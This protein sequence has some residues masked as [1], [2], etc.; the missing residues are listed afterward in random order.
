MKYH[1]QP[2][3][4][5]WLLIQAI[6]H[7]PRAWKVSRPTKPLP[8]ATGESLPSESWYRSNVLIVGD[9]DPRCQ[10]HAPHPQPLW[11]ANRGRN[12][13]GCRRGWYKNTPAP[14]PH[15]LQQESSFAERIQ[16]A[17]CFSLFPFPF[18]YLSVVPCS[19]IFKNI[20]THI[21]LARCYHFYS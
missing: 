11:V 18:S 7:L 4:P 19:C 1:H 17:W 16:S 14:R 2:Q 21:Y 3:P 6:Q 10:T 20:K 12:N 5:F 15:R 13:R 8:R 9:Q